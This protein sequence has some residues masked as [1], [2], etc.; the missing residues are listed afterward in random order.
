M[1]VGHHHFRNPP[2]IQALWGDSQ[3]F[4]S[5]VLFLH[6]D[7]SVHQGF[8]SKLRKQLELQDKVRDHY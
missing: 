2:C 8:S 6:P 5:S 1:V 7:E 4:I 3:N